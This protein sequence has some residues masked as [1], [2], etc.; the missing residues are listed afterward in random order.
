MK[1][2]INKK[3]KEFGLCIIWA[4]TILFFVS[5]DSYTHDLY[6]RWD[7]S[8][9]FT[10]GK[11]WVE[12]LHPY[13]DFADSKG[14]ILWLINALAYILSP[15]NYLGVFWLSVISYA[16]V[17]YIDYKI[18]LLFLKKEKLSWIVVIILPIAYFN[19]WY[20]F[21][22]SAECWCQPFISLVIYRI[23]RLIVLQNYCNKELCITGFILGIGVIWTF[24]IKFSITIMIGISECYCLYIIIREKGNFFKALSFWLLGVFF[25]AAPIT[26][27]LF[28]IGSLEAF[29]TEYLINTMK[30]ISSP[31]PIEIYLHEWLHTFANAFYA[32]LFFICLIGCFHIGKTTSKDRLFLI[33][34]FLGFYSIAIHHNIHRHYLNSCLFFVLF[35]IIYLVYLNREKLLFLNYIKQSVFSAFFLFFYHYDQLDT[36][37]RLFCT[38]LVFFEQPR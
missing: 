38:K 35:F 19:P 10:C 16:L 18:A 20:H 24:L 30:T 36:Y 33:F 11:A 13:I 29:I 21:E 1:H 7:S 32:T 25:I 27:Y 28:Q 2:I 26:L 4:F 9:F 22:T 8:W 3:I 31:N 6:Y 37:R 17:F 12:G 34:S 15:Y 14:P 5:A 23:L